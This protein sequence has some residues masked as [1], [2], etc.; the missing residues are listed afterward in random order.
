MASNIGDIIDQPPT[1]PDDGHDFDTAIFYSITN[2]QQGLSGI[3]FGNFLIKHVAKRLGE[4]LPQLST[5]ATVPAS[6]GST[7]K[8]T[9]RKR[10]CVSRT[11]CW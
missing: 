2:C 10:G 8:A 9:L 6:N 7:G 1:G 11:D 4:E 3:S 5:F